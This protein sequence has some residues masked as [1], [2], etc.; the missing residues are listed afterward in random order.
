MFLIKKINNF[1]GYFQISNAFLITISIQHNLR[2]KSKY[3]TYNQY[4]KRI[5]KTFGYVPDKHGLPNSS[6]LS[7]VKGFQICSS[8]EL[9]S[10]LLF[11]EPLWNLKRKIDKKRQTAPIHMGKHKV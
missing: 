1:L 5:A 3:E 9:R 8:N 10:V 7:E 6:R 2:Y 11:L 4:T